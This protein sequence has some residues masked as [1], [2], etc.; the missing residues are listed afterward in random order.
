MEK[1]THK[2]IVYDI[3]KEVHPNA[4]K[5]SLVRIDGYT[6]CINTEQWEGKTRACFVLPDS[7]VDLARAE[8]K[9]LDDGKGRT[10]Y[11]VRCKKLRGIVSYGF[12]IPIDHLSVNVGDDLAD[13]L[14]ITH[15]D[16]E[17]QSSTGGQNIKAPVH[18]S[19][20]DVDAF[21]KYHRL[22]IDG[23]MIRVTEKLNGANCRIVYKDGEVYVGSRNYW[24]ADEPNSLFWKA[25]RSDPRIEEFIKTNPGVV[26]FG[27]AYGDVKG[28]KY[29]LEGERKFAGFDIWKDG[30]WLDG[31][32]FEQ[33]SSC[34]P[35]VPRLQCMPYEFEAVKK[36]AE[37]KTLVEGADHIREGVVICPVKERIDERLGRVK[38]KI[39]NPEYLE[40]F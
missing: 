18:F 6:I 8:F 31:D 29:G 30:N 24:K 1:S 28:M 25:Y 39:I 23:E 37:G 19:K 7:I 16:P 34:L 10:H 15:Y 4:E 38:V 20:Y 21:L 5:L 36:L 13:I 14:G 40:K 2:A 33:V 35:W 27:E 3:N 17:E 32:E 9:F 11:R 26:L 12:L 22:F